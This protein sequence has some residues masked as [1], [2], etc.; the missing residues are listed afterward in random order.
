MVV[1]DNIRMNML[2]RVTVGDILRRN[3]IRYK[4]KKA[5]ICPLPTGSMIEY[6]WDE[7]NSLINRLA[8]GLTALGIGK[9]DKV[10]IFSLNT[11]QVA[12]LM[13]ALC[14]IG[15]SIAP[16]NASFRGKDITFIVKHSEAKM[17]FVEDT[18]IEIVEQVLPDIK[19]VKMGYIRVTG[20]KEKP[21]EWLDFDE[22]I[23]NYPDNE[24]EVEIDVDDV[25]TLTYTSGTEASP[26]GAMMTHGNICN[27]MT[28]FFQWGIL[29][30]DIC[31]HILPLFYTGGVGTF[32]APLL[33]GQTVVLPHTP[34]PLKMAELM[35]ECKV[36]F[37]VLPPT[38]WVRL[39]Q[40]PGIENA[41]K[42]MRVGCTFG[43]TIPEGMIRGW[44]KIAP[45]MSWISYYGQSETSCSGTVGFF[46][47][48]NEVCEGD[49]AWVGKP[50]HDLEVRVVDENDKDVPVGKVGEILFRGPAVFK[51]YYKDEEKTAK[52]FAG[53]WL[54]SGDL[55]RMNKDGELFFVDRK[56][57]MV[58]SGGENIPTAEI[59]YVVSS[60]PKVAEVA[61]FGVPHPEW[62]EALT[63]AVIPKAGE[64]L[65]EDEILQHC[66]Q[67]LPRFKVPKYILIVDDFPRNATGKILKRELR[68][69]YKD[70]AF[71]RQL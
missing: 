39:L 28:T 40:V 6:T 13:Y 43:A 50:V 23:G 16:V 49:L 29:P 22:L 17:L 46:K 45:Q 2:R 18:L 4:K 37:I 36:T 21:K 9:G 3:S 14:K 27:Y 44:N 12:F 64:N 15:A 20:K 34:D 10:G 1:V 8:N 60:Y 70:L 62:M 47:S 56:K 52:V 35:K 66:R 24:P 68:E 71:R 41:A 30:N 19:D 26:K 57:D 55:G 32:T 59:E 33:M 42:S 54:H 11:P 67:I 69:I 61:V 25:A 31:L 5:L 48:I 65:T 38:L 53:G 51:G 58:K 63:V 7:F